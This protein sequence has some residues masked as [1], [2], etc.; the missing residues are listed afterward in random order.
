[1]HSV[2]SHHRAVAA[3]LAAGWLTAGHITAAWPQAADTRLPVTV[4]AAEIR[5]RPD[6]DVSAEG[7]VVLRQ[8][9]TEIHAD[10]LNYDQRTDVARGTGKVRISRD[11]NVYSGPELQLQLQRFEGYFISPTY[12]FS[13]TEAGGTASRVDFLGRDLAVTTGATYTSCPRDGPDEPAWVL[14]ADRVKMDFATNEGEADGAVLRFYGVPILAAP[15]LSFPLSDDRKSGWLPPTTGLDS[16]SGLLLAVPYYWNLAPNRDAT[17]TP[18]V[19]SKRGVGLGTEFRYLEPSYAGTLNLNVLTNDRLTGHSRGSLGLEHEGVWWRD[20]V[21]KATVARVSDDDY[22]KEFPHD[23]PGL[24]PRLLAADVQASKGFGSWNTY[25]RVLRWQVLQN[26]LSQDTKEQI[27]PVPYDREPQ[28]GARGTQNLGSGFEFALETEYNRFSNPDGTIQPVINGIVQP[29]PITGSRLHALGSLSW[30]YVTPGWT[31]VPKV[32]VNAAAYEVDR[33]LTDGRYAGQTRF[34]RAIPTFSLDSGWTLER[35]TEWFGRA[36]RQ[37]LEPRLLFVRTPFSDQA[38]LPNFDS[39]AKDFNFDSI[40]TDNAFSGIDRVSD[41]AQLTAGVTTRVVDAQT[42]AEAFR[43]GIAQRFLFSDQYVTAEGTPSTQRVSDL[44]LVGSTTLVPQW[45]LSA[46]V[47]YSPNIERTVRSVLG[48]RYSPGPYRT[49]NAAYRF[50]RDTFSPSADGSGTLVSNNDGSEQVELGWQWPIYG[51]VRTPGVRN[52]AQNGSCSGTWYSVGRLNYSLRDSRMTDAVLGFE[53]DAGC[54]I[55]RMVA[56]RLSTS[57]AEA[58]TQL[59]FEIEFVG[60]S[61]LGTNPLKVLKDNIP[62]Y[63]LLR[64]DSPIDGNRPTA[65]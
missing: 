51:P 54:W 60:L 53:Y 56:K 62:G 25:A 7:E 27:Y 8:G 12:F 28:I 23:W 61:R 33:P 5:A 20:G 34:N 35:E 50:K 24:T 47:Q 46:G 18:I 30:P 43:L 4:D 16:K 13:R 63:R 41:A 38:G 19:Y 22:W 2:P 15:H 37:T 26:P 29:V 21:Y 32:S 57:Q 48:A 17:L 55:G 3:C 42:G 65:P 9:P 10:K 45:Q 36:T 31:L 58:T 1:M 6:A 11:G 14:S 40:Y 44:L 39:A 59:G 49:L 52:M 64:D